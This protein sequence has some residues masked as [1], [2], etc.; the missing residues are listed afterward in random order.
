MQTKDYLLRTILSITLVF[1]LTGPVLAFG[2]PIPAVIDYELKKIKV[3]GFNDY[4][5]PL[6]WV[7]VSNKKSVVFAEEM[8][9]PEPDEN[10][11]SFVVSDK[12]KFSSPN[13]ILTRCTDVDEVEAFWFGD[14][15]SGPSSAG[16]GAGGL[17]F[18][19]YRIFEGNLRYGEEVTLA[20]AKFDE[21][22]KK[23]G[24]WQILKQFKCP[25]DESAG[26][27]SLEAALGDGKIGVVFSYEHSVNKKNFV[28]LEGSELQFF[29]TDL[30]GKLIGEIT[31]IPQPKKGQYQ[32]PRAYEPVWNGARWLIPISNTKHRKVWIYLNKFGTE[33]VDNEARIASVSGNPSS[34]KAKNFKF[35]SDGETFMG[36]TY[37]RMSLIPAPAAAPDIAGPSAAGDTYLL[38]FLHLEWIPTLQQKLDAFKLDGGLYTVDWRGKKKGAKTAVKIPKALHYLEDDPFKNVALWNRSFSFLIPAKG[39]MEPSADKHMY[40]FAE[41]TVLALVRSGFPEEW[42]QTFSLYTLNPQGGIVKRIAT[43]GNMDWGYAITM[44]PLINWFNGKIAVINS[45]LKVAVSP[46]TY[47]LNS[48]FSTFVP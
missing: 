22:G 4:D 37:G 23:V 41:A 40:Y 44:S 45:T 2:Q 31:D 28:G 15:S 34:R 24:G 6:E 10:F 27:I 39:M 7:V 3:K 30:D 21:D 29:E 25:D 5:G 20:S 36:Y 46:P 43:S 32:S 14:Q 33:V 42:E 16:K 47:T 18:V 19:V 1:L 17:L 12:G 9:F 38:F 8:K 13:S 35:E 48:Y 11:V 26:S